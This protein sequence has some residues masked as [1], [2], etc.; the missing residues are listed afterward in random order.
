MD[1][2][3][4]RF[5]YSDGGIGR[6]GME[7]DAVLTGIP[8]AAIHNG[9]RLAFGPDGMLWATTGEHAEPGISQDRDSLGGK[10][11]RMTPD[12]RPVRQPV[13]HAGMDVRSSQRA[14]HGVG[15]RRADVRHRTGPEPLRRDQ[16][17]PV[18]TQLRLAG[19]RGSR[20]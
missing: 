1:N 14:G 3:I 15:R 4:V 20:P 9:G 2:R 7:L 11:L 18:G 10:I 13:R 19:H 5:R 8:R 16:Q 17:D 12:G 6:T